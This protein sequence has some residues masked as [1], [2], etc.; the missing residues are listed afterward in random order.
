MGVNIIR[1]DWFV[2]PRT[3]RKYLESSFFHV[4]IQGIKKE[5]VFKKEEYKERYLQL[6]YKYKNE[7]NIE[8]IAYCIMDN[9]AHLLIYSEKIDKLAS[10]M[11]RTNSIYAQHYNKKEERVGYVFRNRY[12]SEEISNEQYLISC[13]NYI[14]TNPVKAGIVKECK[15]YKYS[16]Y[17]DYINNKGNI[18]NKKVEEAL[19]KYNYKDICNLPCDDIYFY[20]VDVNKEE[21]L[22]EA[23]EKYKKG[24]EKSLEEIMQDKQL[25][26]ELIKLL[27]NK[28]K[29]T[30]VDIMKKLRISKGK[31]RLLKK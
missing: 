10:F 18:K 4:I 25:L 21:I 29:I 8:I 2:M 19:G 20:D 31:M 6:I 13:I 22:E 14:H 11:H 16:T 17:N 1:K 5:F 15:E 9:H 23:I 27:K 30:Y 24:K 7:Y 28:Y 3:A 12:V 26:K